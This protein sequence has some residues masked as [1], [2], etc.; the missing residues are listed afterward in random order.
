[1]FKPRVVHSIRRLRQRVINDVPGVRLALHFFP[2]CAVPFVKHINFTSNQ[3]VT[4][5]NW[6]FVLPSV[7]VLLIE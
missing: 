6:E 4:P 1:M 3:P 7:L 2:L 5:A